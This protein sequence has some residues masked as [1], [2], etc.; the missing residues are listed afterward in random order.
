MPGATDGTPKY[1]DR[2]ARD[3]TVDAGAMHGSDALVPQ[4][5]V[6]APVAVGDIIL[7]SGAPARWVPLADVAVGSYLRSGGVTTAPLW[8]TLILPNVAT[9][10]RLPVATSANTIG[11]LVA[12]GANGEYLAGATGAIPAWATLNQ[13]AVA[14]LKTT[15][16]PVFVTVKLSGLTD[17]YIPYHVND[18]TGLANGPTKTNV[19]SAVSLKHAAVTLAAS[20]DAIMDL[21]GQ[22]LALETQTANTV[23]AGPTT[24]AAAAPDFR[25][26]VAAD[27]PDASLYQTA[28]AAVVLTAGDF[29]NIYNDGGTLKARLADC[30]LNRPADGYVLAGYGIG[31]TATVYL[32]GH[33]TSLAGLTIGD[34]LYLSTI[35]DATATAPTAS[36][37]IVQPIGQAFTATKAVYHREHSILL[38]T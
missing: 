17:D 16:S 26:L 37:Y 21:A 20:A 24:G 10:F 36:G 18:T 28:I 29:V 25:A 30:S 11:E 7:A 32:E 19:D 2:S 23:L 15:D 4:M 33:N 31:A 13:A 34:M 38:A 14:D 35:G 6:P 12:S 22:A 5:H 8:S 27:I 9:A 3:V 1:G